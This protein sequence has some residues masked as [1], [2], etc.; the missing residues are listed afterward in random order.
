MSKRPGV[1]DV[2]TMDPLP[3]DRQLRQPSQDVAAYIVSRIPMGKPETTAGDLCRSL[4]GQGLDTAEVVFVVDDDRRLAGAVRLTDVL[5]AD[6]G[7]SLAE[8]MDRQWPRTSVR[9]DREAAAT[10]AIR[11]DA[12][13]L[14][15]IDEAGRLTGALPASAIMEILRD[16]H[17]EDLHHMA[18]IL[19]RSEAARAALTAPP[20][21]RALYRLPWLLV[22]MAGSA[23][24]TA[25]MAG[26]EQELSAHIAVAVFVPAIVYLADAVG[27]QTEAVA[28]RGLSLTT[29]GIAGLLMG[30]IATGLLI[31]LALALIAFPLVVVTFGEIR[32][33]AAV[34]L[35]LFGAGAL[36]TT[37]GFLLP[38]AMSRL[39]TDPAWGSG[40]IATVLQD[41]LSL[42]IYLGIANVLIF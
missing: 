23:G 29:N 36:A 27:T 14:A 2:P 9:S 16:E 28:V 35:A 39:G 40:P 18:G 41:V 10:L 25:L 20:P 4:V 38:L 34:A 7:L 3:A 22:G 31:G 21:H 32:L 30:E 8:M 11:C 1:I 19:G 15:V 6:Q 24:V 33:A 12:P 13:A 37:M 17:L 42:L 26:F 5:A